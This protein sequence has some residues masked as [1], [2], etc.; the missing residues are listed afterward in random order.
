MCSGIYILGIEKFENCGI[1]ILGI[2][3]F[4]NLFILSPARS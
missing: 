3:K 2:E 1:Y 4:E